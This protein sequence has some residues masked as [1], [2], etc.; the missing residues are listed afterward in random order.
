MKI[1]CNFSLFIYCIAG[2]LIGLCGLMAQI[3]PSP[4]NANVSYR[5]TQRANGQANAQMVEVLTVGT[6][7]SLSIATVK[8]PLVIYG[9]SGQVVIP[10]G[11]SISDASQQFWI[12]VAKGFPEARQAIIDS[13]K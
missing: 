13:A 12:A 3:V 7:G 9:Q 8:G 11:L 6:D 10:K 2:A 4:P 1:K 5:V